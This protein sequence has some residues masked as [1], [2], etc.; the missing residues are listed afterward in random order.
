M[1]LNA[2]C[3][4]SSLAIDRFQLVFTS[5][6]DVPNGH[7]ICNISGNGT[8]QEDFISDSDDGEELL[9]GSRSLG[10]GESRRAAWRMR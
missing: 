6:S 5:V 9:R 2:W 3:M 10:L 7:R 8:P 1:I 4:D